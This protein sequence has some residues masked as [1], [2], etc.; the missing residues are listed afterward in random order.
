MLKLNYFISVLKKIY[1][2]IKINKLGSFIFFAFIFIILLWIALPPNLTCPDGFYHTKMAIL[3]K[4]QGVVKNF[5]WM[6]F[7]TY[8]ENFVDQHF[9]YHLFL[10]PFL[11]LPSPKNLDAFSLETEPLLKTKLAAVILSSFVFL[12]IYL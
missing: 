2:F 4:E 7:T 1:H 6:Y 5:P 9:G 3:M 10:I 8:R 12:L 11:F